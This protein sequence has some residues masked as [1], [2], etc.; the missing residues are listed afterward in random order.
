MINDFPLI[1]T[2]YNIL[3]KYIFDSIAWQ[4]L[5]K[6]EVPVV[7]LSNGLSTKERAASVTIGKP[8][9]PFSFEICK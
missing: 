3:E 9:A 1:F 7:S 2:N 4:E 8:I 6:A 5:N